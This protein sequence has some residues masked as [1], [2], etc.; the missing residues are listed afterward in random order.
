MHATDT[1]DEQQQADP[2][3]IPGDEPMSVHEY[4]LL[5]NEVEN[6]PYWRVTADKEMDYAD[7]NQLDSELLRKQQE[8]GIPPAI[9][10]LIGP[11]LLSV[12][13]YEAMTRTDW[14]VTP[15]GEPGGQDVA[16]ALNYK[17][18]QAERSS[19]ADRACSDAFRPQI[20]CGLGWVEVSRES[21][22]FK[23]PYRCRAVHRNEIHWDM[24]AKCPMLTDAR[25]LRRQ[26][27]MSP[28]R[29]ALVFP[30][31]RELIMRCGTHGGGWWSEIGQGLDGGISTGLQNAWNDAR[32]W[33]HSEEY[34]FNP[35]SEEVA[36]T[37]LWYRRWVRVPV[38]KAPN[39]RVVEYDENNMAHAVAVASGTVTVKMAVVARVRRS[40]WLGPHRLHDGP[41]P[42]TH[43]QFPY[44]PFWGF[45]EDN[46]GIPY[47]FVRGMKYAQDS[48][49]SGNSKLRWGMS[50]MRVERTKGA[51]DMSDAQLR[52]QVAR[53]D[54]DIVL[55]AEHMARTGARF[56]V[57]RDYNLSEQHFHMLQDNRQSIERVSA[58]TA[59]FKGR[60]GTARSGLQEQTQVEQ[61][62]Q[63]LARL[64]DNFRAG[65]TQVGELLMA[66]IIEDMGKEPVT[67]VIE[68]DAVRADRT[69][70]LNA[71]EVDPA[72]G[73]RY[74][75]NDLQRTRLKV[76][77]EDVPSTSSYRSQ[78]LQALTEA[79][80]PLPQQYLAAAIPFLTTLMDV[81][82]KR[83]LVEAF[84]AVG[85]APTP[86]QVQQQ[87]ADAVKDAL[88]KAGNDIKLREVEL[89]ERKADS[90]IKGMDAKTVQVMVQAM[91]A[92]MQSGTQIAQMPMI[93]P[94]ADEV[95]KGAGYQRP[96]PEGDDPDFPTPEVQAAVQMK[97]PYLQGQ[98]R[99]DESG[100]PVVVEDVP[101]N[102]SPGFPPVPDDGDSP[103][104]GIETP[105][106]DDNLPAG[107]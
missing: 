11:A 71:P 7:G 55:N 1:Y 107:A 74:L 66:M 49:N 69:V 79:I 31:H 84:R 101:Q 103:M 86:E 100:Q 106:I 93:A 80:K 37:E 98:G 47:G 14:R 35:S 85:D 51:V 53:P 26:R 56:E 87:I 77:L 36:L 13:G 42:Y 78:Q 25:W 2:T 12:Q 76:S 88:A 41:S 97:E 15:D 20:G 23:A 44:V 67:V 104:Q 5:I 39:G 6:Q 4:S 32:A 95:M 94:I 81:P 105:R 54:A 61:S 16:D 91:F 43:R 17:L 99:P 29:A 38:I 48:L 9:E 75:T 10:D 62:N 34:W 89:K 33:T 52:R 8:L 19:G 73:E 40:Y 30:A 68:G 21:D 72:T 64:M 65:R 96:T 83:D 102:T 82:F 70:Q 28:E 18:N 46:T 22:P 27:W 63:S 50:V 59:G 58:I 3:R 92:A 60:E 45:V 57:K 24:R 90:E